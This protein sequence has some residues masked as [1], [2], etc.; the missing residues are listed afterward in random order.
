LPY[1]TKSD[2]DNVFGVKNVIQWSN[3]DNTDTSASTARIDEAV[4]QADT[5]IDDMMRGGMYAIPFVGTS[6]NLEQIK[7]I[8]A[9]LAGVWLYRA[10]GVSEVDD[11]GKPIDK[12][13][14]R[15]K[16][17]VGK[18]KRYLSG[19]EQLPAVRSGSHQPTSPTVI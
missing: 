18:L 15:K 16:E 4:L 19:A 12:M 7:N 8:S 17:A 10:R 11:L 6:G 1:S 5:E 13:A 2:I 3:L 14:A 9:V